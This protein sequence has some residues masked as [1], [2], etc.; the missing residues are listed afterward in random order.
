VGPRAWFNNLLGGDEVIPG[1]PDDIVVV[2]EVPLPESEMV[3]GELRNQGIP[4][5]GDDAFHASSA[6]QRHDA[7]GSFGVIGQAAAVTPTARI[8]VQR[9][10]ADE[11]LA[12]L[13]DLLGEGFYPGK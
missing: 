9:K 2:A 1:D 8:A 10:H 12:I 11:A 7:F 3:V 6:A 13:H 5:Y 4:A